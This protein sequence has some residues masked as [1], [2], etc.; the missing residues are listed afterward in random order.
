MNPI[1]YS[2]SYWRFY[3]KRSLLLMLSVT[4]G[5]ALSTVLWQTQ[6]DVEQ[7]WQKD[8]AGIDLVVGAKGSSLQ[9]LLAAVL[10]VDIPSGNISYDT[11]DQLKKNRMIKNIVPVSLG[12]NFGGYRIVGTDHG[13]LGLYHA[14]L[15]EGQIW[16][17]KMQLVMG[18]EAARKSGKHIGDTIAGTH[19]FALHGEV[20][21]QFPYK[22]V[23]I[24]K[25][26]GTVLD[27]LIL[28]DTQSV[29]YIHS[30][31]DED[32]LATDPEA[33]KHAKEVT[34]ALIQY[35]SPLV[36]A[37]LPR[38]INKETN[39][40]AVSPALAFNQLWQLIGPVN[41]LLHA[42]ALALI[43]LGYAHLATTMAQ[44]T[45]NR[46]QEFGVLRAL[47]ASSSKL[48]GYFLSDALLFGIGVTIV[49]ILLGQIAWYIL[50]TQFGVFAYNLS[51]AA[52]L[53]QTQLL[54]GAGSILVVI[55]I[56]LPIYLSIRKKPT[57]VLLS[58]E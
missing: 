25:P 43:V 50:P 48:G 11:Y 15:A 39:A 16:N 46:R 54:V 52:C 51:S 45:T 32:E 38:A 2:V 36:A 47:G 41:L 13:F 12:D 58:H 28:T 56:M 31:P 22:V 7:H 20:H 35:R 34:A 14:E 26:T 8:L 49:S 4:F 40:Q 18:A 42:V 9:L 23:G 3:W 57:A 44:Q 30:H 6:H 1:A 29:W 33:A 24:L 5:L 37:S 27:R 53:L 10:H 17:D 55:L 19:G 21:E